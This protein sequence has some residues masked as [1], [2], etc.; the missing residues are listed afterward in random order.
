MIQFDTE[1]NCF[2]LERF[3]AFLSDSSISDVRVHYR[4]A[5][6]FDTDSESEPNLMDLLPHFSLTL[7]DSTRHGENCGLSAFPPFLRTLKECV[8]HAPFV[9]L[10]IRGDSAVVKD[11]RRHRIDSF[12]TRSNANSLKDA[13]VD[14]T[15]FSS[16]LHDFDAVLI[17]SSCVGFDGRA[18][19]FLGMDD[20][21]KTTAATLCG[22]GVVLSDDQNLFRKQS[23]G[24][25]LAWGT[26]WTTFKPFT[27]SAVPGAFFLLEKAE[28]FSLHRVSSNELFSFLWDEH[29]PSRF[30]LPKIYQTRLFNLYRDLSRTAPAYLMRFPKD[31]VD[32]GAIL[33]CLNT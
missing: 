10:E 30:M 16:F 31:C 18:A 25:W 15:V 29:Y 7:N 17:H 6:D 8:D 24:S 14:P 2:D 1:M 13:R 5:E 32:R 27:G 26:P 19:V 4:L 22:E 21:G 3:Q 9:N 12:H 20:G 28:E 23:D 11:Y 33:K